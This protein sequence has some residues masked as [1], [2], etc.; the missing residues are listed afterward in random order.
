MRSIMRLS[1]C[2]AQVERVLLPAMLRIAMQA[3]PNAL[4]GTRVIELGQLD[5]S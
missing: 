4:A 2:F 3:G 5:P 1:F